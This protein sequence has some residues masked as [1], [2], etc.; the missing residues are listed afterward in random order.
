MCSVTVCSVG[1][2]LAKPDGPVSETGGSGISRIMN[3]SSKIMTVDPDDWKTPLVRY[4]E[5][6]CHIIDRKVQWQ[7]LKYVMLDNTLYC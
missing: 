3:E 1:P 7:A 4:L 6:P 2:S 5:N